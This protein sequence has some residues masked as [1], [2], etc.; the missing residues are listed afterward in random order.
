VEEQIDSVRDQTET[1]EAEQKSLAKQIAFATVQLKLG[2]EYK[3]S[4]TPGQISTGTR[5]HNVI[6]EGFQMVGDA[7]IGLLL[8]L[9]SY[10]PVLVLIAALLFFPARIIWKHR[11]P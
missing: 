9:L 8:F 1:T 4:L 6:V 2:E 7:V 3:K 5:L 10:G 11:R